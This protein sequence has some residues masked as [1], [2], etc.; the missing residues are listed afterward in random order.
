MTD[1][2]NVPD[3]IETIGEDAA[4]ALL[5]LLEVGEMRMVADADGADAEDV[6][7]EIARLRL[8]VAINDWT[9]GQLTLALLDGYGFLKHDGCRDCFRLS[10]LG[11]EALEFMRGVEGD[12]IE[13]V[14]D[15]KGMN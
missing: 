8:G 12:E 15:T 3:F 1:D 13:V 5:E 14:V 6:D 2:I 9:H 11:V 10:E 7:Y 4:D